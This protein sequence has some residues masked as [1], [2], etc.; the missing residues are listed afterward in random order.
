MIMEQSNS[1]NQD[2][3]TIPTP[4]LLWGWVGVIPFASICFVFGLAEPSLA[5][6]AQKALAPYG[7]I[8]LTFMGGVHWGL[9][10]IREAPENLLYTTGIGPSLF[11]VV[12]ILLPVQLALIILSM[13]FVGLL[14][15]DLWLMR[16]GCVPRWYGQ[17]RIQLTSAV[18]ICLAVAGVMM[19]GSVA[20]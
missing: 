10:M 8:V 13:G 16:V 19:P 18:L 15:F 9:Q 6:F 12:A 14:L 7:A 1:A 17:L 11:A 4:A 2:N 3:G 5:A 20:G